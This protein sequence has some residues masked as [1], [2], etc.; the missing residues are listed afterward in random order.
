MK[1]N[2]EI[3]SQELTEFFSSLPVASYYNC[4]SIEDKIIDAIFK[5]TQQEE[6]DKLITKPE[7]LYNGITH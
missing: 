2:I 3:S 1:I 4:R 6:K 5:K 7:E